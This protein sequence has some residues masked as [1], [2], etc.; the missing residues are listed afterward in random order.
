MWERNEGQ[1][2]KEWRSILLRKIEAQKN[3]HEV[4]TLAES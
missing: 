1:E 2:A 3:I 4:V